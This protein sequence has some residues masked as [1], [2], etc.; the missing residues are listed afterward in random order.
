S[1]WVDGPTLNGFVR[2]ILD[3]PNAV[4]ALATTWMRLGQELRKAKFAHGNL[5]A[6]NVLVQL[7]ADIAKPILRLVDYDAIYIPALAGSPPEDM[8]DA[9]FQHPQRAWQKAYGPEIDRFPLLVVYTALQALAAE[10][11]ALWERH[12]NGHNLLF[13]ANDFQHPDTSG[14]FQELWRSGEG[15]LRNLT[16]HL[17]LASQGNVADVPL[18][19]Q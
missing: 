4:R 11:E 12:D 5:C 3:Q 1:R 9:N 17:L 13:T 15:T 10:G 19:H 7:G 8:G 6:E 2:E 14:L 18:L 16:G